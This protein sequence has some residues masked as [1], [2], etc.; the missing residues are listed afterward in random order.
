MYRVLSDCSRNRHSGKNVV[1][2]KLGNDVITVKALRDSPVLGDE[3]DILVP[4]MDFLRVLSSGHTL[5]R[6]QFPLVPAYS[7]QYSQLDWRRFIET[8]LH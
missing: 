4:R 8:G 5:S 2:T 3:E 6:R 7:I 1:V